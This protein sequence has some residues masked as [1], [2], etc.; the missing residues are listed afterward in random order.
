MCKGMLIHLHLD[1]QI[2]KMCIRDSSYINTDVYGSFALAG[3]IFLD[4][5][6]YTSPRGMT[7]SLQSRTATCC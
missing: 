6:L 5:L 4:C 3:S 2:G 1:W 7:C